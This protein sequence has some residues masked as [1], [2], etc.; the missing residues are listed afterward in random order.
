[1]KT[2]KSGSQILNTLTNET[3]TLAKVTETRISW[4]GKE[5]YRTLGSIRTKA[6]ALWITMKQLDKNLESGAM[7][8][9]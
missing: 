6:V 4:Y 7:I 1:M 3:I 9:I 2:L 8:I 5:E